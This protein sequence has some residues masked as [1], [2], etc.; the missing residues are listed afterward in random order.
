M[1]LVF[2]Q[3]N[4]PY[5]EVLAYLLANVEKKLKV[6]LASFDA[7]NPVVLHILPTEEDNTKKMLLGKCSISRYFARIATKPLYTSLS[8]PNQIT[9]DDVL[10]NVRNGRI[11][12][13]LKVINAANGN[14]ILG[15]DISLADIV[16]YDYFKV[17]PQQKSSEAFNNW[18]AKIDSLP[19]ASEAAKIIKN[20][21]NTADVNDIFKLK[22]A[23]QLSTLSGVEKKTIF[24]LLSPP[25][26]PEYGDFSVPVARLRLQGNP[27]ALAKEFSE[28]VII[29]IKIIFLNILIIIIFFFKKKINSKIQ[30]IIIYL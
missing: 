27:V 2:E 18:F 10:D 13:V 25:A 29:N 11:S 15:S 21:L 19:E 1:F 20:A 26:K 5:A 7:V 23:E 22:I 3:S 12:E 30:I 24:G 4:L 8:L 28:K 14:F 16:A 9:V 17:N 6:G